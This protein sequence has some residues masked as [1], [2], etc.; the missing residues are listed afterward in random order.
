MN[1]NNIIVSFFSCV[2]SNAAKKDKHYTASLVGF[3]AGIL[4]WQFIGE[5]GLMG[6][7]LL[8][9]SDDMREVIERFDG[10]VRPGKK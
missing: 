2:A 8:R 9:V 7:C 3:A 5:I 10:L 4:L 6:E 1:V